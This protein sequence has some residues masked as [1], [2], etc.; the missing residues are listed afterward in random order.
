M[1][2]EVFVFMV[3]V[4]GVVFIVPTGYIIFAAGK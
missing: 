1:A 2:H 4:L 3:F